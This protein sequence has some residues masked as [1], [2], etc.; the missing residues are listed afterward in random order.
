[1]TQEI[2]QVRPC[3][4]ADLPALHALEPHPAAHLAQDH[5]ERQARGDYLFVIAWRNGIPL[6]SSVLDWD[7]AN[8]WCP[9]LKNLWVYPEHRR[10]GVARAL[11]SSLEGAAA[12]HG[13]QE[14]FLRVDPNNAAAIPMYVGM[15]YSPTGH[16]VMTYYE[17]V[18]SA[19]AL[20][21]VEQQDAVYR[22]SLLAR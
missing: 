6:G 19:G 17:W 1:M 2:I 14:V 13:F 11:T 4:P 18:D 7:P 5:C 9:E 12:E 16:H 21:A 3:T 15:D 20:H 22:K 10:Q 8:Q